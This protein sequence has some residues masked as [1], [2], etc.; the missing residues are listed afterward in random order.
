MKSKGLRVEM[1]KRVVIFSVLSGRKT[2]KE[3]ERRLP[4]H[5]GNGEEK[6]IDENRKRRCASFWCPVTCTRSRYGDQ[7]RKVK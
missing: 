4:V 1:S 7:Y 3:E 6:C 2:S 5:L